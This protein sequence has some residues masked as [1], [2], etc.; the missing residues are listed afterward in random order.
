MQ[1]GVPVITSNSSSLPEVIGDAGI[2]V[3]PHDTE[4]LCQAL[5]DLLSDEDLRNRLSAKGLERA[6]SFSWEK[7][8]AATAAVY[9]TAIDNR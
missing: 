1:C 2:M 8:A 6:G 9:K 4:A 7:A 3:E 5:L